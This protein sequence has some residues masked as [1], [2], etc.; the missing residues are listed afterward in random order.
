MHEDFIMPSRGIAIFI[1]PRHA[2]SR[3]ADRH[4]RCAALLIGCIGYRNVP[5]LLLTAKAFTLCVYYPRA[6]HCEGPP[7]FIRGKG[8]SQ[9]MRHCY[10]P[11]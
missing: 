8:V 6:V 2:A 1:H 9:K 10:I 11:V 7:S 4:A 3:H 5:L